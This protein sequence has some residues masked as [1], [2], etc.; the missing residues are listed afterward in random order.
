MSKLKNIFK[1]AQKNEKLQQQGK[2]T[3]NNF[4]VNTNGMSY[5][6]FKKAMK[7]NGWDANSK[8]ARGFFYTQ[9]DPDIAPIEQEEVIQKVELPYTIES[10]KVTLPIN[11][12][13][14]IGKEKVKITPKVITTEQNKPKKWYE[15]QDWSTDQ[16]I[17]PVNS[18]NKNNWGVDQ[19]VSIIEPKVVKTSNVKNSNTSNNRIYM[20]VGQTTSPAGYSGD[21]N[22]PI[23]NGLVWIGNKLYNVGKQLWETRESAFSPNNRLYLTQGKSTVSRKQGGKMNKLQTGGQVKSTSKEQD[24]VMQFVK[25]LA[26]TLQA[27]PQQVI[28]AAQQNPEAL[29]SAVQVY[30]ESKGDIQ[31]AAQAFSQAISSKT[32]AAKH[33]AKLNYLKSLKNKCA[34]DEELVYFKKGGKVGCGCVKKTQEGGNVPKKESSVM[35]FKKTIE[36]K[37][38]TAK[39]SIKLDPKTT[40]TLPNGKYPSNWTADDKITWEREHGPKDEGAHHAKSQKQGG[41]VKKDCGGSKMKLKKGDKVCPKCGKVHAAGI[42]C[43]VAKFKYRK[44]GGQL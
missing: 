17:V 38:Q 43:S 21:G 32:Q 2:L 1:Q 20:R 22:G 4:Y 36:S 24:A 23:H 35:K 31:K 16:V 3:T 27:D 40:K 19:P 6:D 12:V 37:N 44:L 34:E 9:L 15:G 13:I 25:A 26:Q 10:K 39:D 33:G 14:P 18:G 30:Q 5:K 41:E 28:Q 11:P 7:A 42:G 8:E 29:K